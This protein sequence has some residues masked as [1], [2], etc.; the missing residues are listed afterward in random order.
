MSEHGTGTGTRIGTGT[1]TGTKLQ[2]EILRVVLGYLSSSV[3]LNSGNLGSQCE[4][5]IAVLPRLMSSK[6]GTSAGGMTGDMT[7]LE[8][9]EIGQQSDVSVIGYNTVPPLSH[10][11]L[12]HSARFLKPPQS[13]LTMPNHVP[14]LS[15]IASWIGAR[16][17][18][19][20]HPLSL[21]DAITF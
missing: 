1:G 17:L 8:L 13:C 3:E 11:L 7:G 14:R 9:D 15:F 16:T 19:G 18:V 21:R 20:M 12:P 6:G 10:M 4:A 5:V 2:T